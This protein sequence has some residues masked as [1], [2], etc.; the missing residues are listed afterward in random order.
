MIPNSNPQAT[1]PLADVEK[2]RRTLEDAASAAV[3]AQAD[4]IAHEVVTAVWNAV[5]DERGRIADGWR[6][7][8]EKAEAEAERLRGRVNEL[9]SRFCECEPVREHDDYRR[10]AAYQHAAGCPVSDGAGER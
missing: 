7:R 3:E 8:A 10:P 1:E 4:E 2:F 6:A 9:E 5:D